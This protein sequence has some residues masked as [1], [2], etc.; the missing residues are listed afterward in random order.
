[1]RGVA[2]RRLEQVL[3]ESAAFRRAY[4]SLPLDVLLST[5]GA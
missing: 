3:E 1:V 2:L 4:A 5:E